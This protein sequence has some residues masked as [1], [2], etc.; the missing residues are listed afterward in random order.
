MSVGFMSWSADL[1]P[2]P[3]RVGPGE[4]RRMNEVCEQ[5]YSL[6]DS[7]SRTGKVGI[8]VHGI[9][10]GIAD[11]RQVTPE[12]RRAGESIP[13]GRHHNDL[14]RRLQH[15]FPVDALRVGFGLA[16]AILSAGSGDHFRNPM[17]GTEQWIDPFQKHH[18]PNRLAGQQLRH[19]G[20]PLGVLRDQRLRGRTPPDGISHFQNVLVD[21][22]DGPRSQPEHARS[23]GQLAERA[24]QLVSRR[25]ADLAEILGEDDRGRA[26]PSRHLVYRVQPRSALQ[27]V[28]DRSIDFLRPEAFEL[29]RGP[30]RRRE[31][32]DFS[33]IVALV[34]T[35]EQVR[36]GAEGV[37]DLG[38]RRE[39]R[40]DP[41]SF[42]HTIFASVK[43]RSASYPPYSPT[44][45]CFM[46]PKGTL[47]SL[48]SQVLTH[49]VPQAI[50]AATRWARVRSRVQSEAA[51]P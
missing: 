31:P 11:A 48:S 9:Y 35:A 37:D 40:N 28:G 51:R 19:P 4:F 42:T 33:R 49:T 32:G 5:L 38:A 8:G 41:H 34:R 16:Q 50:R 17:P 47:R 27:A 15:V 2:G 18:P 26:L 39:K 13:A 7:R 46:P 43:K 21:L 1:R 10:R 44:P 12:L 14:R 22:G 30:A 6:G 23:A 45:L 36:A 24:A 20:D 25:R 3:A 29:R